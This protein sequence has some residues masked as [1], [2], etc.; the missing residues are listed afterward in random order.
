MVAI[1]AQI[2]ELRAVSSL[3]I[4]KGPGDWVL[5][6]L[7][8][9]GD[10]RFPKQRCHLTTELLVAAFQRATLA[11]AEGDKQVARADP[12]TRLDV[13]LGD[14]FAR[15]ADELLVAERSYPLVGTIEERRPRRQ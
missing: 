8:P 13:C 4:R 15:P 5:L 2:A 6:R 7:R 1:G 14:L 9:S 3:T 11:L 12:L 10:G